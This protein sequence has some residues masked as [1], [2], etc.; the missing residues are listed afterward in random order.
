[1]EIL[2]RKAVIW[3]AE[4]IR[5]IYQHYVDHT[6]AT[7][8]TGKVSRE[9]YEEKIQAASYPFWV[10]EKNGKIL[11]FAYAAQLRSKEAY[12]WDVEL[13]IYLHSLAPVRCGI[14]HDLYERLLAEIEK[15][16][17]RN[18]YGVITEGN[19]GSLAFHERFG[20]QEVACFP[21]MGYK[22]G[23]WHDVV[24]MHKSFGS[25]EGIPELPIPFQKSE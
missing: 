4:E 23:A 14:G 5:E 2:Y 10:A 7:F 9:E 1:M 21:K 22:H 8:A 24:W 18:A 16:G 13:T 6:S 3:D 12:I 17:F 15:L 11:G 19:L 25:F 20:F